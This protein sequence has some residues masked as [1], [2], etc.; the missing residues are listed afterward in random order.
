MIFEMEP[1]VST[2]TVAAKIVAKRDSVEAVKAE[3]FKLVAPTRKESGCIE[4]SLH[5]DN[6]D[7]SIFLFY[8][9]WESTASIEKHI[10]T[11]HYKAYVKALEGLLEEKVVNKMTRIV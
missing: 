3:L 4:Y 6:S 1:D 2:I 11:D 9:T 8:E 5:Q 10:N 7:P